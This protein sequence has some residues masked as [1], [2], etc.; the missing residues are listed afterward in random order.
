MVNDRRIGSDSCWNRQFSS[1]ASIRQD[2]G[3]KTTRDDFDL[4]G[5]PRVS[6]SH[7]PTRRASLPALGPWFRSRAW[8]PRCLR[9]RRE[10]PPF[11]SS[12]VFPPSH[13]LTPP[14]VINSSLPSPHTSSDQ[15]LTSSKESNAALHSASGS[16][17]PQRAPH[18]PRAL[19]VSTPQRITRAA[20][21][22][23]APPHCSLLQP[24]LY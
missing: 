18:L 14:A 7:S 22:R 13:N 9:H 1:G 8:T 21:Q 4:G 17:S 23:A 12:P 19:R 20:Q 2:T 10:L 16:A 15:N 6:Q 5:T 3:A 24:P 11:P